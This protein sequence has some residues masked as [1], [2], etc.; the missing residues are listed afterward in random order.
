[1]N[2]VPFHGVLAMSIVVVS[3]VGAQVETESSAEKDDPTDAIEYIQHAVQSHS[4]VCLTEG[5]HQAKEP[6]QFLRRVLS[7]S[8][9]LSTLDVIIVEFANAKHQ[10]VLDAYIEGK[11][12]PFAKLSNVWRDTGQSPVGPWDSPLYHQLLEVIRDGNRDLP[13]EKK[14]RVLAGDP[15][16]DW[17]QIK[18]RQDYLAARIA[19][20]PYVAELAVEQAFRLGK[21]VLIIFGG[22]HLPR[23][24]IAPEDPRNSL[25]SRILKQHPDAVKAIG[26][27][28]PEHLGVEDRIDE[29][30]RETIYP[31]DRHWVGQ[32]HAGLFFPELYSPVTDPDTGERRWQKVQ[33]YS[34]YR[35]RDLFD[36][37][38]YIGPSSEWEIVPGSFDQERDEEY[39][40]ELNRRSLL[41]FGRPR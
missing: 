13:A 15:L 36:A 8:T 6:H 3:T 4:I 5:G 22:A 2:Q 32:I 28:D 41:R 24:P 12:I 14:V 1:M 21:K 9:I 33:L 25:T 11:D 37:L 26:F 29:L 35:V 38:V 7:D 18:T 27:L 10:A 40:R 17:K 20:D 16:I 39:L 31:T 19:R 30:V 23:V 34:E